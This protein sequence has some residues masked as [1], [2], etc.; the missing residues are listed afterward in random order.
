MSTFRSARTC[1]QYNR[2][3]AKATSGRF[4]HASTIT[5]NQIVLK[6]FSSNWICSF[7]S[8]HTRNSNASA[9]K[10]F[11]HHTITHSLTHTH[12]R[13]MPNNNERS[14]KKCKFTDLWQTNKRK[15]K[16][17]TKKTEIFSDCR[18]DD[19]CSSPFPHFAFSSFIRHFVIW[20]IIHCGNFRVDFFSFFFPF[21]E[22]WIFVSFD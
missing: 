14:D 3:G 9:A 20:A 18:V 1:I 22:I 10:W 16:H 12:A 19:N 2:N 21:P 17:T 7:L 6:R 5:L 15:H 11:N 4:Y 13:R 8:R